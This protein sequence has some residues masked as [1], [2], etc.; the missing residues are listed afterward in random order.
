MQEAYQRYGKINLFCHCAPLRCHGETIA[1]YLE[2]R[3]VSKEERID[4]A[5]F[6][7]NK[8]FAGSTDKLTKEKTKEFLDWALHEYNTGTPVIPDH[9]YD[10]ILEKYLSIYGE[11]NRPYLRNTQST[12]VNDIVGTLTKCFNITK[13]FRE[14][15]KCYKDWA[16]K[17]NCCKVLIQPKLNGCSVAEDHVTKQFFT[18][19]N[20][21]DGESIN[22]TDLFENHQT[23][24]PSGIYQS[25][26]YEAIMAEETFRSL[27][28]VSTDGKP[29]VDAR[30]AVSGILMS[31]DRELAK[32]IDLIPLRSMKNHSQEIRGP[33]DDVCDR[34][35]I[36]DYDYLQEFVKSILE[37]GAK[38]EINGKTYDVD[39]VVVSV[40][41]NDVDEIVVDPTNEVAIKILFDVKEA[42]LLNVVNQFGTSG[43]IT[44]VAKITPV[45]FDG[46]EVTSPTLSTLNR[47]VKLGLRYN[48]T[49]RVTFNVVPYLLDSKGDGDLPIPIP[50]NCPM[51]GGE[52]DMSSL[53]QVK[54]RNVDCDGLKLGAIIRYAKKLN[55]YGVS[56]ATITA[57]WDAGIVRS[58]PDLYTLTLES[59]MRVDGFQEKSAQKVLDEIKKSSTNI[60]MHRWLGAW[61]MEDIGSRVWE[62]I[63]QQAE[64]NWTDSGTFLMLLRDT[65]NSTSNLELYP[66]I[67]WLFTKSGIPFSG[68]GDKIRERIMNGIDRN[69]T[70]MYEVYPY[71]SFKTKSQQKSKGKICISGT[72]NKELIAYLESK[73]Y[74]VTDSLSKSCN[75]LLTVD[76]DSPKSEKARKLGI[77]VI[78]IDVNNN[79]DEIK[80]K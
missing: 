64:T 32:A 13:P 43:R 50:T 35:D 67:N 57:F 11:R 73:G 22:V 34:I 54:C 41:L 20:K 47:V 33:L 62:S 29:Y 8:M 36:H 14:D 49:V 75:A 46:R 63:I 51:C 39:G 5:M 3:T 53:R 69:Q 1:K 65:F 60:N 78:V 6:E 4:S 45:M 56:N 27:Q 66:T 17:R 59:I 7:I 26:K 76:G 9:E 28:L 16:S 72:R 52:F 61:P 18:R 74:E 58:I 24:V 31:R 70:Q 37:D 42:K 44:P 38:T 71:M 55:M 15:Q 68:I 12:A 30:A 48:D 10:R 25:S 40:I 80:I 79:F 23:N 2:G 19:G 77:D 21:E